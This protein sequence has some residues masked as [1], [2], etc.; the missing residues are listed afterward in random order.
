MRSSAATGRLERAL[1]VS[2][3]GLAKPRPNFDALIIPEDTPRRRMVPFVDFEAAPRPAQHQ[4][5]PLDW[6]C[7]RADQQRM[8]QAVPGD[9][10]AIAAA[11]VARWP[12]HPPDYLLDSPEKRHL[13]ALRAFDGGE[14][15]PCRIL[16]SVET[17]G[18]STL[19]HYHLG[20]PESAAAPH[21]LFNRANIRRWKRAIKTHFKG[22]LRWK[23]ELGENRIHV[24]ILADLNDGP[25]SYRVA[26]ASCAPV[27]AIS[28]PPC[29]TSASPPRP[30]PPR[31]WPSGSRRS[32]GAACPN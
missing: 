30:I 5:A 16:S 27:K 32:P 22:P 13:L 6:E 12:K 11:Y 18:H 29:S 1:D 19:H 24:H 26:V 3:H 28:R 14:G 20:L 10:R 25:P 2:H 8:L 31:P 17:L 4:R 7:A 21:L 23:L 15:W 9:Y